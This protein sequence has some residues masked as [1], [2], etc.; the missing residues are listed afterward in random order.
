[1]NVAKD[2]FGPAMELLFQEAAHLMR[3]RASLSNITYQRSVE[4]IHAASKTLLTMESN[5]PQVCHQQEIY[6]RRG[7]RLWSFLDPVREIH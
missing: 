2:E 5:D 4:A 3:R 7:D 6:R 1:M